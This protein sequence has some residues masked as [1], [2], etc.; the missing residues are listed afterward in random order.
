MDKREKVAGPLKDLYRQS[1]CQA[2]QLAA[3]IYT[4]AGSSRSLEFLQKL[5]SGKY[6]EIVSASIDPMDYSNA[7]SF[8]RDYL[9]VELMS[10]FPHWDLGIDRSAV[11]LS[12]FLETEQRLSSLDLAWNP[13]L[14]FLNKRATMR[15]IEMIARRKIAK[16]LGEFSWDEAHSL[17][18]FG[19]GASTSQP[20]RQGDASFKFGA[21]RPHL[22]YNAEILASA[23]ARAH[24]SWQ[25][26][27]DV[28]AGSRLVTVPKNAK[29]DRAICIEPDLNMYFQKGIGGMI[30]K[31]LRRWGLLTPQAQQINAK[32]AQIGSANGRLA[33]VDLS[34]ASDSLHMDVVRMLLPSDWC[35]AIEQ[36][37]SP[38]VV[39][40]SGEVHLL[41]KVSSMGNGFT[42]ELETLVFYS[43]CLAV[44]ESF[45][46]TESD[47]QCTVFGDDIIIASE[48]VEPLRTVLSYFGFEMNSKKTYAVGKFRESCGKHYFAGT[49]VTPFYIRDKV[50]SVHRLYWA[51]NTV[52]RYSRLPVW[53]LDSRYQPVYDMLVSCIPEQFRKYKIP[54]G[55]GDGGLVVDW[56]EARP[57]RSERSWDAWHY[58]D[59]IPRFKKKKIGGVGVLL[60]NLHSLEFPASPEAQGSIHC[61]IPYM[62]GDPNDHQDMV[63]RRPTSM[64]AAFVAA[65]KA[66]VR[67]SSPSEL[68]KPSGFKVHE[69]FAHQWPSYGPWL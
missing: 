35:D 39:L 40:P 46:T 63:S 22:S 16:I 61:W 20:R 32:L 23:L 17:F 56:D 4:A 68:P 28:V 58:T 48:L 62:F 51:A 42:F 33:T 5:Y 55:Y 36:T 45:A 13:G 7:D 34:N 12:K 64:D 57:S 69:G 43:L 24:P 2:D 44:I 11:A 18:A 54:D 6:I 9:C 15:S 50:D 14:A 37:R 67:E 65:V 52:R 19:P 3:A 38:H 30:R 10:K 53:G 41:R 26:S 25:F 8:S 60:K 66:A 27:A 31:R 29:T 49:D 21:I 47:R 1:A 59:L